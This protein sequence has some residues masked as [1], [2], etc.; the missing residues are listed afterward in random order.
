MTGR[1]VLLA[2]LLAAVPAAATQ[3]PPQAP[4]QAQQPANGAIVAE[5]PCVFPNYDE[6][7]SFTRRYYTRAEYSTTTAKADV[8][9]LR[10]QYL[11]DGLKVVGFLVKPRATGTTPLP[12]IVYNRGGFRDIGMLEPWHL[13]DFY[14]FASQ[15]FVVMASQ[16]RG[17]DGGEGRDEVGGADLADVMA[18]AQLVR[19]LPYADPSNVFLYGLSRGGMMSFLA[20]KRGFAARAAAVVGAV[21]DLDAFGRRSPQV[22]DGASRS[23]PDFATNGPAILRE[24]SAMNWPEVIDVPLLILHGADDQE[25]P[26]TEAMAF[27]TKLALL[28]KRYQLIV[29]AADIHEVAVN[30]ADRDARI[31]AWFKAFERSQP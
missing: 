15:G 25:V 23:I 7:S 20:L 27:A 1:V 8:E 26:A 6:S 22:M 5:A 4:A 16:Y 19:Q 24:R 10:I 14:G 11:S 9:C 12:V 21:F 3:T 13:L 30:R 31:A 2:A 17:N 28:H 18:L 29:Y